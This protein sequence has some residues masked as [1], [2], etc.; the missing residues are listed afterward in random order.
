MNFKDND[1][2]T[3]VQSISDMIL[4][5]TSEVYSTL[6]T[7]NTT[8]ESFKGED[9]VS[10]IYKD[11]L[12]LCA[13]FI[14]MGIITITTGILCVYGAAAPETPKFVLSGNGDI[15]LKAGKQK[16]FYSTK[17]TEG[18]SPAGP[19]HETIATAEFTIKAGVEV[20]AIVKD[21]ANLPNDIKTSFD[22]VEKTEWL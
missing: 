7:I 16:S 9:S 20:S 13:V 11:N 18:G 5:I 3:V 17:A 22:P 6:E 21:L 4:S 12:N 8:I 15:V 10:S 14:D 1:P 2:V 19:I